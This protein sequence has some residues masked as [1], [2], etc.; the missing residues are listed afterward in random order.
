MDRELTNAEK[1]QAVLNTLELLSVP[2]TFDNV[3]RMT[4]I[5]QTLA[6]VRDALAAEKTEVADSAD[7]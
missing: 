1:I 2:P 7:A 6:E 5:Y 4:G 3:N